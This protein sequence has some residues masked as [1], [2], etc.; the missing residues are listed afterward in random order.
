MMNDLLERHRKLDGESRT[1]QKPFISGWKTCHPYVKD[2]LR[3]QDLNLTA[4]QLGSYR[5]L[6]D[7]D[8][9]ALRIAKFHQLRD[10]LSYSANTMYIAP[11]A[12]P[13]LFATLT[14]LLN[15]GFSEVYFIPPIYYTF[16]YFSEILKLPLKA[17]T[18][19]PAPAGITAPFLN[20]PNHRAA[21]IVSDPV[22][23]F[24]APLHQDTVEQLANWQQ[25]TDSIVVVDGTFQYLKWGDS[26]QVE[27]TSIL[28]QDK[29]IRIV[30]PTKSLCVHG[31][32]FAYALLPDGWREQIRYPC[33][34]ACGANSAFDLAI[35]LL[36]PLTPFT[37]S[38]KQGSIPLM[39][40]SWIIVTS[41]STCLRSTFA[42]I[43]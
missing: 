31:V 10:S 2:Y 5:F 4:E 20:L 35:P 33:S 15:S 14:A 18:R 7:L 19:S 42:L 22:W 29:T 40:T 6:G 26:I 21:L 11:G 9:L 12:S 39:P 28:A 17:V 1:G 37:A 36:N 32:R 34:N 24:G 13:L 41:I 38:P 8:A 16:Y 23:I 3:L 27:S 30:C 25:S 43:S